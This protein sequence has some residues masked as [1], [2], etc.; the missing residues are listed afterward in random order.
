MEGQ[1]GGTLQ[2]A[3]PNGQVSLGNGLP[4]G[5][6]QRAFPSPQVV[7]SSGTLPPLP[8]SNCTLP[9]KPGAPTSL[10]LAV[11]LLGSLLTQGVVWEL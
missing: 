1:E 4:G 10:S 8:H 11:P 2:P 7:S 5:P 6:K 9:G 3:E